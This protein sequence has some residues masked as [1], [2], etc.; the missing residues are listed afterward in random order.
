MD[1]PLHGHFRTV[2]R[3]AL[4]DQFG[5]DLVR[6][7]LHSLQTE[8]A[9]WTRRVFFPCKS[10]TVISDGHP[11]FLALEV[12]ID[13]DLLGICVTDYIRERLLRDPDQL[14]LDVARQW[15]VCTHHLEIHF[16]AACGS[17]LLDDVR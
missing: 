8:M 17:H 1:H 12:Q 7:L 6:S 5:I 10:P 2:P 16:H 11:E 3:S 9:I 14:I 13:A 15:S 4:H